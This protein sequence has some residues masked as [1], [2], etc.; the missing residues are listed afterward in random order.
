MTDLPYTI[1]EALW[2]L[3]GW[4][5]QAGDQLTI[6]GPDIIPGAWELAPVVGRTQLAGAV[7]LERAWRPPVGEYQAEIREILFVG[8]DWITTYAAGES[9]YKIEGDLAVRAVVVRL[10]TGEVLRQRILVCNVADPAAEI[11]AWKAGS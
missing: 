7:D 1:A 3:D 11:L 8:Y 5:P 4:I 6:K 10:D 2:L 9:K